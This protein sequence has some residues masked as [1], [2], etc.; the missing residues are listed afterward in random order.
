[1]TDYVETLDSGADTAA[2]TTEI[3]VVE[4]DR[5]FLTTSLNDYSVTEGLLLCIL[6]VLLLKWVAGVI[7]EEF[8]WLL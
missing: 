2:E 3:V 1:M 5:P 6:L 4:P 8:Y 7:K